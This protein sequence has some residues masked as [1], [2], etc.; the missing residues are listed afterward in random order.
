MS[1]WDKRISDHAIWAELKA[2]GEAIDRA[3]T[4]EGIS[5]ES[6]AGVERLRTIL[7]LC[8][9]RLASVDPIL[10]DPRVP[11]ALNK[12]LITVKGELD[13]FAGDGNPEHISNAN[14][15]GDEIIPILG[16]I[17]APV[18]SEEITLINSAV[19]ALRK[20]VDDHLQ[21]TLAKQKEIDAATSA[22]GEKLTALT[23]ALD[24]EQQRLATL[25][26]D[27]QTQF[28]ST[29]DKRASDFSAVQAD[30]QTKFAAA[31]S[32]Q[33]SQFSS[34]QDSRKAT[35]ANASLEQQ[36]K[37]TQLIS[38]Y[39]HRLKD[40]ESNFAQKAEVQSNEH[41]EDLGALKSNYERE[42]VKLLVE[43]Q[44]HK[45]DVE[46]LVGVIGNLSVTSGYLKVANHARWMQYLWQVLTVV[47]LG[48]LI[49]V[50]SLVAFPRER[51][52]ADI[53][54]AQTQF[55]SAKYDA[56]VAPVDS[57]K[58]E[59]PTPQAVASRAKSEYEFLEGFASRLFLSIAFGIFAAYAA[60][61]ARHFSETEQ[62]N[63]KRAL[64]LEAFGPF[65]EPLDKEAKDKFRLEIGE[66][67]FAVPDHA[68]HRQSETEP[69][70][71]P[72]LVKEVTE[73]IANLV[74]AVRS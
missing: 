24:R 44:Q 17:P 51:A 72:A 20:A 39:S 19:A 71:A 3:L 7:S 13:A 5:V 58:T 2:T 4:R 10:I 28:S 57:P 70:T 53:Q 15:R 49:Y 12:H 45:K 59:A 30:Q 47:A 21:A 69:V 25:L 23:A 73:S 1:Q 9:K 37:F 48:G 42:A 34:E 52:T 18:D 41:K 16:S 36:E 62:K 65:I 56:K 14:V 6:I 66:R 27:Y 60:R 54:L 8:G 29:Q 22:N 74:K 35:F 43:I 11:A 68:P 50:A 46:K 55:P 64:E 32:E 40:Q 63:R 26:T 31:M 38:E 33:Q 61:Q 67:S